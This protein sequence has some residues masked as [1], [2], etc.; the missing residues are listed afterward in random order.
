MTTGR[1]FGGNLDPQS[2]VQQTDKF[3]RIVGC[4]Y[5]YKS[6]ASAAGVLPFASVTALCSRV[7]SDLHVIGKTLANYAAEASEAKGQQAKTKEERL[8]DAN[9]L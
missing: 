7:P 1:A 8:T 2:L 6:T 9:R 5:L 3:D 4:R